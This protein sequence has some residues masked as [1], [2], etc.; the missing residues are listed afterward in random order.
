MLQ[1]SKISVA[2]NLIINILRAVGTLLF[3]RHLD[4]EVSRYSNPKYSFCFISTKPD[5]WSRLR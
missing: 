2:E 4:N 1:Q 5:V 3:R